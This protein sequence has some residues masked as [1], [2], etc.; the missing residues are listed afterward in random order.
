[1]WPCST[2][3]GASCGSTTPSP[4][5][6]GGPRTP[7]S[8]TPFTDL[9]PEHRDKMETHLRRTL[10]AAGEPPR[11]RL[12]HRGSAGDRGPRV[13][14]EPRP[15]RPGRRARRRAR[16]RRRLLRAEQ[17]RGAAHLPRGP[18]PADRAATTDAGST[19]SSTRTCDGHAVRAARRTPARRPRQLQGGQRH[20]GPRRGGRAASSRSPRSSPARCARAT[21]WPASGGDEFAVLLAGADQTAAETV[22]ATLIDA[23]QRPRRARSRGSAGGSPPASASRPSPTPP[24]RASTRS[25]SPTCS[26]TTPRTPAAT[27][28]RSSSPR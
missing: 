17:V 2:S 15:H 8:G 3:R 23:V 14:D 6:P 1:M 5:W 28:S 19:R 24:S 20:D 26:S 21:T 22:A 7:S 9:S 27:S 13:A 11:R 16:Q 4:R 25:R 12:E 18:R 10:A